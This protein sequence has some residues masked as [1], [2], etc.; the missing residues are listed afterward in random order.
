MK[1]QTA[2]MGEIEVEASQII[3]FEHGIPGFEDEKQFVLLP[4][5]SNDMFF[6]LQ[7]LETAELAFIITNPY[8][9]TTNYSF[10]LEDSIVHALQIQDEKEVAI[11][12]IVSLKETIEQSTINLKAPIVLNTTNY[13]AKQVILNNENFAIRHLLSTESIKG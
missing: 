5:E 8:T 6:V 10:E 2:Y 9:V 3:Y 13:K 4:V 1:I 12:A 7:S 11:F